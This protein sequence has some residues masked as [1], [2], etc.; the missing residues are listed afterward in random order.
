MYHFGQSIK[1]EPAGYERP[2]LRYVRRADRER[3]FKGKKKGFFF[4]VESKFKT[5]GPIPLLPL[6]WERFRLM[7]MKDRVEEVFDGKKG[8]FSNFLFHLKVH[9]N[10]IRLITQCPP[11]KSSL[12]VFFSHNAR[13][14]NELI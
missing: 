14:W 7:G 12:G 11:Y 9:T 8:R 13:K 1:V 4:C 3:L 6:P 2:K 10:L 5:N